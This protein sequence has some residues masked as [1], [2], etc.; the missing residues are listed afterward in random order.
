MQS[1]VNGSHGSS[2]KR[3]GSDS[4][5]AHPRR[6]RHLVFIN[7]DH[8]SEDA[9]REVTSRPSTSQ[10]FSGVH[11]L[12]VIIIMLSTKMLPSIFQQNDCGIDAGYLSHRQV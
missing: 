1:L 12:Q 2:L 6:R 7:S 3:S 5:V 10:A 11:T 4:D 8:L 9:A